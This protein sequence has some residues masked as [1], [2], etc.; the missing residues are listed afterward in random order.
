MN[1]QF[2]LP[3]SLDELIP[4]NHQVRVI[5]AA[6]ERMNIEP[7]IMPLEWFIKKSRKFL[8]QNGYM[9]CVLQN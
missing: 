9:F 3:P 2:L 7:H 8:L 6:I 1:Q 5:E 4:A